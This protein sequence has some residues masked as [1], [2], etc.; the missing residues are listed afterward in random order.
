[1]SL[2]FKPPR[3]YDLPV[4]RFGDLY[5]QFSWNEPIPATDP[6]QYEPADFPAGSTVALRLYN[7]KQPATVISG[8]GTPVGGTVD[9]RIESTEL[10][11]VREGWLWSVELIDS[12]DPAFNR[13]FGNGMV[14]RYDGDRR[15]TC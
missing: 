5:V 9:V 3:T 4:S 7:P 13:V 2:L 11:V 15:V 14:V 10:D 6:V 1:M 12:D 8:T